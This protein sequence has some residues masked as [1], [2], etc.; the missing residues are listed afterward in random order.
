[1][2][3]PGFTVRENLMAGAH[4]VSAGVAAANMERTLEIFPILRD[5]ISQI[6]GTLSGG[7]QQMLAIGRALMS[8]PEILLLDEPSLG[9]APIIVDQVMDLVVNINK[10]QNVTIMLVEQNAF[11]ALESSNRAYVLENGVIT[12]SGVSSELIRKEELKK[13]YLAG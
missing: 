8:D 2:I 11:L 5:R 7:E 3:V 12:M 13:R 6:A 10:N 4:I 9:L 1:L